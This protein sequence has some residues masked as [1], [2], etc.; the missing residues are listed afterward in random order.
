MPTRPSAPPRIGFVFLK[1]RICLG[2]PSDLASRQR[3]CL[4]LTVSAINLRE[5]LAPSS[6]RPCW[7]YKKCAAG[8][9]PAAHSAATDRIVSSLIT[10][11][12]VAA[13]SE[14]GQG[15]ARCRDFDIRPSAVVVLVRFQ[16]PVG[17]VRRALEPVIPRAQRRNINVLIRDV[18]AIPISIT[19]RY[20]HDGFEGARIAFGAHFGRALLC[21]NRI[22]RGARQGEL[23][24]KAV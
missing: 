18:P 19:D 6:Q 7:A 17:F 23:V 12:R 3:P 10:R 5:G 9:E 24:G 8:V 16:E 13:L 4:W 21:V 15:R 1:S 2:L 20:A 14:Y 11:Y 22:R